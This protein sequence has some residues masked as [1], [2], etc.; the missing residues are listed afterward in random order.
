MCGSRRPT[1]SMHPGSSVPNRFPGPSSPF[2]KNRKVTSEVPT[3][4]GHRSTKI[5]HSC[6]QVRF[7]EEQHLVTEKNPQNYEQTPRFEQEI[8]L[9]R[10]LFFLDNEQQELL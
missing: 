8:F 6:A 2:P 10:T 3:A 1:I 7:C 5:I 4:R 9:I